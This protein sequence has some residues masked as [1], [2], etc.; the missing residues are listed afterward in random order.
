MICFE[1]IYLASVVSKSKIPPNIQAMS[2]VYG[3]DTV[4]LVMGCQV[5]THTISYGG[6]DHPAAYLD[7]GT[8]HVVLAREGGGDYVVLTAP[9]AGGLAV[10]NFRIKAPVR[11]IRLE[12][13]VFVAACMAV[14]GQPFSLEVSKCH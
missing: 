14:N 4:R 7:L 6:N 9:A 3:L 8:K 11:P 13:A 1:S 2:R 12:A 5:G 10:E